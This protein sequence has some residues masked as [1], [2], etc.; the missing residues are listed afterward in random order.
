MAVVRHCKSRTKHPKICFHIYPLYEMDPGGGGSENCYRIIKYDKV[1]GGG[2][3]NVG[4]GRKGV[5]LRSV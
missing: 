5:S 2:V 3:E 1:G 4:S